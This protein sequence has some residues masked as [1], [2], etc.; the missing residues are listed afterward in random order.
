MDALCMCPWRLAGVLDLLDLELQV[1]VS[2]HGDAGT[3]P[4][5]SR[6]ALSHRAMPLASSVML[7]IKTLESVPVTK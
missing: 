2:Y 4:R 3:E 6:R 5:S 1:V 7:L